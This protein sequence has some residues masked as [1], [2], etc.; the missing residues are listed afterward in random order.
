MSP[1]QLE[2][3]RELSDRAQP[4]DEWG[5]IMAD[6]EKR[7]NML[8]SMLNGSRAYV[9]DSMLLIDAS[10]VAREL[11]RK[12]LARS[13]IK[14]AMQTV[15]GRE[16]SLGPYQPSSKVQEEKRSPAQSLLDAARQ[17]GIPVNED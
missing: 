10:P 5:R 14:T 2:R 4:F 15:L 12:D 8:F 1:A 3:I 16:Y 13:S 7:N 17:G 9:V 11:L 6:L